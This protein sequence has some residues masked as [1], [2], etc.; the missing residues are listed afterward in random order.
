[1]GR[2][3]FRVRGAGGT[4]AFFAPTIGPKEI[5]SPGSRPWGDTSPD[6]LV[7]VGDT[8]R[9][10]NLAIYGGP[11]DLTPRLNALADRSLRF[12]Q[13]RS[14]STSTLPAHSS[15]FTGLSPTQHGATR[16]RALSREL[17]R[18]AQG[19]H[20]AGYRTA[21][22]S[23]SGYVSR[24]F[25]MDVGFESFD[26]RAFLQRP[27]VRLLDDVRHTRAADDGRPLF[28][29]VQTYRVHNPFRSGL[30]EDQSARR[31]FLE[32]MR[33]AF[34]AKRPEARRGLLSVEAL[35]EE[36]YAK[37]G[38][39]YRDLYLDGVRAF[40]LALGEF[41]DELDAEGYAERGYLIFTAD[42]GEE[43][44]EHGGRGH[45]GPAFEERVR[46][47]LLMRGPG[48]EPGDVEWACSL[49]DVAP[50]V[51]RL[52]GLDPLPRAVGRDLLTLNM[53]RPMLFY[54]ASTSEEYLVALDEGRKLFFE[55][56]DLERSGIRAAFDLNTDPAEQVDL[57]S[58]SP[59]W[60]ESM[61]AK[62]AP[63]WSVLGQPVGTS[64]RADIDPGLAEHLRALGYAE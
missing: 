26:E 1:R 5:G 9:A 27:F 37:H 54:N 45:G 49:L 23:D 43:F 42:H 17:P 58:E 31:A 34:R 51:L 48:I 47:P 60:I 44:F 56:P 61:R 33:A 50:T 64:E 38:D 29:F 30:E 19:L 4:T 16:H 55:E 57:A 62:L 22:V 6:I 53:E 52:A 13:A 46:I 36:A 28:L 10:D 8:F 20:E 21:A 2:F 35:V 39:R 3:T 41:L 7:F 14:P 24:Q 18:L 11:P 25:G 32:E 59:E 15:L 12:L 40:D 63:L